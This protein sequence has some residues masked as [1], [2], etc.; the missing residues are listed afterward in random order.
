MRE[1]LLTPIPIIQQAM[2]GKLSPQAG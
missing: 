1:H 2:A